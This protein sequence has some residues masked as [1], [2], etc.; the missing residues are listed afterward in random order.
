MELVIKTDDKGKQ[1]IDLNVELLA[2]AL[3]KTSTFQ[4]S[5]F[6]QNDKVILI[7]TILTELSKYNIEFEELHSI[8]KTIKCVIDNVKSSITLINDD[9]IRSNN[10]NNKIHTELNIRL[11]VIEVVTILSLFW[12]ILIFILYLYN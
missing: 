6:T 11:K 8:D 1:S 3:H 2:T 12:S 5:Y 4:N 7:N 10:E 9:I